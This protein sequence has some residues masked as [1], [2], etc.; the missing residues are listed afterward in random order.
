MLYRIFCGAFPFTG[1]NQDEL[2][3]NIREGVYIPL[4]LAAPGLDPVM[5]EIIT[6]ALSTVAL[7]KT[8]RIRPAPQAMYE[9][10]GGA[11]ARHVSSWVK[12]VDS[13]ERERIKTELDKYGKKKSRLVKTRRFIIRNTGTLIIS[14]LAVIS[15]I[16]I[17]RGAIKRQE[18]MPNTR[19]MTPIEVAQKY[20]GS[21]AELDHM[22]MDACVVGRTGRSDIEMVISLYVT[23][24]SVQ[25][26]EYIRYI[27]PAQE[28][29]DAGS[30]PTDRTVFGV[31]DLKTGYLSINEEAGTANLDVEYILWTPGSYGNDV[32]EAMAFDPES[33]TEE[34]A[35]FMPDA[36]FIKDRLSFTLR[37]DA[38]RISGIDRT[39]QQ[40][41]TR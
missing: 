24:R 4:N 26:Y 15:A 18:G 3:E 7:N 32:I 11:E 27:I 16:L 34:N 21:F 10:I 28:W 17:V 29:V 22:Y 41:N 39:V 30:Q 14:I 20:Y 13:E 35:F 1:N 2:A 37:K 23:A 33:Y 40:L 5:C 25:A 6:K 31:T 36:F 12:P 9:I 38:W 19:G 8:Q